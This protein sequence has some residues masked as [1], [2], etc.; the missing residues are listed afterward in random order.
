MYDVN[1]F[2]SFAFFFYEQN[3]KNWEF[4]EKKVFA[5]IFP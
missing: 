3:A 5:Q 2:E 1:F 4:S